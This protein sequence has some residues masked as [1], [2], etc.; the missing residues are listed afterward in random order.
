MVEREKVFGESI[1]GVLLYGGE[2]FMGSFSVCPASNPPRRHAAELTGSALTCDPHGTRHWLSVTACKRAIVIPYIAAAPIDIREGGCLLPSV[3]KTAG[4]A[5][6]HSCVGAAHA[7]RSLWRR[8]GTGGLQEHR[9]GDQER[10][11][12]SVKDFHG[13][14]FRCV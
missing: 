10:C 11:K 13:R 2:H 14:S 12:R 7:I 6:F 1:D 5:V 3:G 8:L 4:S 9:A